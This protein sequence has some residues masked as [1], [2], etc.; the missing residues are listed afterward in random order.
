M[1][2]YYQCK[3]LKNNIDTHKHLKIYYNIELFIHEITIVLQNA[4]M[5]I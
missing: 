2:T 5:I 3:K 1:I 4:I